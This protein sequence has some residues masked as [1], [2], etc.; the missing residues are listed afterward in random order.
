[1]T[2]HQGG[3]VLRGYAVCR[4]WLSSTRRIFTALH[5]DGGERKCPSKQM[6]LKSLHLRAETSVSFYRRVNVSAYLYLW[7]EFMGC[8]PVCTSDSML[9]REHVV[10]NGIKKFNKKTTGGRKFNLCKSHANL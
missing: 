5:S 8:L 6:S 9:V 10:E 3:R 1:M 2:L 7:S 4:L